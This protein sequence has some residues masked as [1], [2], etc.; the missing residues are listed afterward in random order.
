MKKLRPKQKKWLDRRSLKL[1]NKKYRRRRRCHINDIA[2]TE[3][4]LLPKF[5]AKYFEAPLIFSFTINP[6]DTIGFFNL[7]IKEI[8]KQKVKQDFFVDSSKI[9][10][11][12]IDALIYMIAIAYNIST[13]EKM[14]YSLCGNLPNDENAKSKFTNSGYLGYFSSKRLKLTQSKDKLKILYGTKNDPYQAKLICDYTR[15]K[16]GEDYKTNVLYEMLIELMGNTYHHAYKNEEIM[17]HEWYI[18]ADGDE[19]RVE[20]TFIDVGAG[21]PQT[22]SKRFIE[23]LPLPLVTDSNLILSALKGEARTETKLNHRGTGL[24]Y[25][26]DKCINGYIKEFVVISCAGAC[27]LIRDN[28]GIYFVK[29]EYNCKVNGTI[30]K[31]SLVNER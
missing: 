27:E 24:P 8:R 25:L 18:Y 13:N 28:K 1:Q 30:F 5:S 15:K 3:E 21:I 20:Y 9:L 11:V 19:R 4:S 31:W 7:L 17:T 26:Y 14:R 10:S 6:Q 22:I 12:T 16:F 2:C 23:K 29:K